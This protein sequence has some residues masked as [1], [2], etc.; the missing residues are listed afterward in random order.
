MQAANAPVMTW[1]GEWAL[2]DFYFLKTN[3]Q[4]TEQV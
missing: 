1:A 2:L 3:K 4:K